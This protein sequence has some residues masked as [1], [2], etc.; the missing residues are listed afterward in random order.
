[1]TNLRYPETFNIEVV[2]QVIE[3]GQSVVDVSCCVLCQRIKERYVFIRDRLHPVP[4]TG[5]PPK[6]LLCLA[7]TTEVNAPMGQLI[8]LVK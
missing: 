7:E 3:R 6:C 5:S 2:K 1:M 8:G 4:S